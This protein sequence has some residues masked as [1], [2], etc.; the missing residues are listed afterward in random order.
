MTVDIIHTEDQPWL[1]F[2]MD[3]DLEHVSE[4]LLVITVNLISWLMTMSA[5]NQSSPKY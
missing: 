3:N 5:H 4:S 1:C 2:L